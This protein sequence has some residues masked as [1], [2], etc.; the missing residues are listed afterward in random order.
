METTRRR[1]A[2]SL[3]H[4]GG[5]S[6]RLSCVREVP[7]EGEGEVAAATTT[8]VDD[9]NV[10][11][12]SLGSAAADPTVAAVCSAGIFFCERVVRTNVNGELV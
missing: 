7:E 2:K 8:A 4:C 9:C 12:R 6:S 3:E 11:S 1:R 10:R 5:G